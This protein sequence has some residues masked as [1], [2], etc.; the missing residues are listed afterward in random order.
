MATLGMVGLGRMGGNMA[1]RLRR[2]GHTVVGFDRSESSG[3]DVAS[4]EELVQALPTPRTVWV[5][6]PAGD[7]T[8]QTVD[9]LAELLEPGDVVVD[10]GNSYWRE[11]IAR[12][13]RMKA[14]AI[15]FVD[16]GAVAPGRYEL[17]CAPLKLV[18]LDGSPCRA[19]LATSEVT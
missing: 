2:G 10:G 12:H 7:P 16:L 15:G 8:Y 11:S 6:V 19:V 4:L 17:I 1:E 13:A 14:R 9:A 5:M 3:R 18:G